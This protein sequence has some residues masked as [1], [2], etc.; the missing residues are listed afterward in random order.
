MVD[1]IVK[2]GGERRIFTNADTNR[3]SAE[4][5]FAGGYLEITIQG[6]LDGA[7]VSTLFL[8]A[9]ENPRAFAPIREASWWTSGQDEYN[10]IDGALTYIEIPTIILFQIA[11]AGA[12]TNINMWATPLGEGV[13]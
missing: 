9:K 7:D 13:V 1:S 5:P 6:N 4:Y 2:P 11:N 12:S 8:A 10:G 3:F